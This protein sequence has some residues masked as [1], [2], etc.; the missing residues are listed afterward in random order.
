MTDDHGQTEESANAQRK[1]IEDLTHHPEMQ[2]IAATARPRG[3]ERS[4]QPEHDKP[5]KQR[6]QRRLASIAEA[7]ERDPQI[8]K[9]IKERE[10]ARTNKAGAKRPLSTPRPDAE[11]DGQQMLPVSAQ[12]DARQHVNLPAPLANTD[13]VVPGRELYN[14]QIA[15]PFDYDLIQHTAAAPPE[16]EPRFEVG[17]LPGMEPGPSKVPCALLDLFGSAP[18][19]GHGGPV[20]VWGR[21]GW[22]ALLA[23]EPGD[24]HGRTADLEIGCGNMSALVW[25]TT[26]YKPSRHGPLLL[27][28]AQMLNSPASAVRWRGSARAARILLV[29]VYMPPEVPYD[30]DGRIGFYVTR[31]EGSHQGPQVDSSLLRYLRAKGWRLHRIMV[32]GYCLWTATRR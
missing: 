9:R 27:E 7:A 24:Y 3:P 32:T 21:M 5:D 22:E 28:A 23:P 29:M 11:T 19:R 12:W 6:M 16:A 13:H 31:P 20:P 8:E 2:Q 10:K 18:S 1:R 17:Y 4:P 25:P 14:G 30:R 15:L 26:D